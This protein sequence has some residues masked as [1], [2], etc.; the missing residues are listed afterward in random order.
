MTVIRAGCKGRIAYKDIFLQVASVSRKEYFTI[1]QSAQGKY[2]DS[3]RSGKQDFTYT[4]QLTAIREALVAAG[5]TDAVEEAD[6]RFVAEHHG[7]RSEESWE[8]YWAECHSNDN[9]PEDAL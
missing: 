4:A 6:E 9:I 3:V 5:Y 1:S 2:A 8:K 7:F